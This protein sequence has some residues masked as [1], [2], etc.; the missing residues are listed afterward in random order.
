M[1]I[2][3][4]VKC[5][6]IISMLSSL[7]ILYGSTIFLYFFWSL[8]SCITD[9]APF[10]AFLFVSRKVTNFSCAGLGFHITSY[11][12]DGFKLHLIQTYL[13]LGS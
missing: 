3:V 4:N 6:V 12:I 9:L 7:F 1:L 13:K 2:G 10:L 11:Y 5:V 8:G